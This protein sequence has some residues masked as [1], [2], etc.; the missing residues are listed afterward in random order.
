MERTTHV[1]NTERASQAELQFAG[2]YLNLLGLLLLLIGLGSYIRSAG[3]PFGL[4]EVLLSGGLGTVLLVGGAY[5]YT[6]GLT[7]YSKPLL[8]AGLCLDFFSLCSA[9]FRHQ[10]ISQGALFLG[11]LCLVVIANLA[12]FKLD[13]K[14]IGTAMLIVC[15]FAP[16][17][18]TFRF[19][20][21]S[22]IFIYLLAVNLGS[23][24]VAFYKRW[25]FQLLA[26]ALGSYALYFFH[27]RDEE[28]VRS[29]CMLALI[30]ALSL[31]GNNLLYFVRPQVSDYNIVLSFVNPT[32]FAVLSAVV[33]LRMPN[34]VAVA[35]YLILATVHGV[36]AREADTRREK[37]ENFLPLATTNLSLSLLFL[38][39]AVSFM[40]Y[41]SNETTFFGPVTLL[42]FGLALTLQQASFR[43]ERHGLVLSRFS[44]LALLLAGAQAWY[45]LPSMPDSL[46]L[47]WMSVALYSVYLGVML[48]RHRQLSE[49]Q[50]SMLYL[51]VGLGTWLL[52]TLATDT[53]STVYLILFAGVFAALSA[54]LPL[55]QNELPYLEVLPHLAGVYLCL[56]ALRSTGQ[57]GAV[58]ALIVAT[59]IFGI[60]IQAGIVRKSS[61]ANLWLWPAFLLCYLTAT[62]AHSIPLPGLYASLG[63]HLVLF[64][65][66]LNLRGRSEL[67]LLCFLPLCALVCIS[68]L[69][70][71]TYLDLSICF[72]ALGL[73][74][75]AALNHSQESAHTELIGMAG[76]LAAGFFKT[77]QID[78]Y[79]CYLAAAF[80]GALFWRFRAWRL[81]LAS[82]A[83]LTVTLLGSHFKLQPA[84]QAVLLLVLATTFILSYRWGR[85]LDSVEEIY[86]SLSAA[87][88]LL[89]FGKL[90]YLLAP[91]SFST[92][93]WALLATLGL[94]YCK[95]HGLETDDWRAQYGNLFDH[96]RIL[97]IA[98]FIKAVFYDANFNAVMSGP[99]F[100]WAVLLGALFL[101]Q[102]HFGV[103]VREIRNMFIVAG[104]LVFCFQAAFLLHG[105]WGDRAVLQPLLS[106]FWSLVGFLSVWVGVRACLKVY[107]Y[108]GLVTLVGNTAKILVVDIHVLDAYS[109][110]NTYLILGVMLMLTSL[111]YQKQQ[112]RLLGRTGPE[113][114][115]A[116]S[117]L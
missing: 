65:A 79:I 9:H 107:R 29:L 54:A 69:A 82:Q 41:F 88:G 21:F 26:A 103:R 27:F 20:S 17:F 46:V 38:Y 11:L 23:A 108:F 80:V 96:T 28:A 71:W 10:F 59:A 3:A 15:F 56:L 32:V 52:W 22:T 86:P 114:E 13:A 102:A 92:L 83:F 63:A 104:L 30:Y 72:A 16:V 73:A 67:R 8:A 31:I 7:Q 93:I 70:H 12:A 43:L 50:K 4:L 14:I 78:P 35:S 112:D 111:L 1:D 81:G 44:Y 34:W 24:A 40:T 68:W 49:R 5:L 106:G 58:A 33:I 87:G 75:R 36:L 84:Q 60:S 51:F 47:R 95:K 42:L 61:L 90:S 89:T 19:Q 110:V 113:L 45:V 97:F 74:Y 101:S 37:N 18:I 99:H 62:A 25:D 76:L 85:S 117:P 6:C 100:F 55:R 94:R 66:S 48:I 116:V 53:L 91:G 39:V 77:Y 98:C 64:A 109:K 105:L 57:L 2:N 115:E